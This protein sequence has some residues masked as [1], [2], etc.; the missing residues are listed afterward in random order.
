LKNSDVTEVVSQLK[1][2]SALFSAGETRAKKAGAALRI[3]PW[4]GIT[5]NMCNSDMITPMMSAEGTINMGDLR[6][7]S[8]GNF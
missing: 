8:P 3:F 1:I 5:G 2:A 6:A 4:W 7:C